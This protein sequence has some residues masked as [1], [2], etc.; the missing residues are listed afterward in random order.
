MATVVA[1]SGAARPSQRSPSG[2][3]AVAFAVGL[4]ALLL[5]A[6]MVATAALSAAGRLPFA[7]D[8][9][10]T[11]AEA[12]ALQ[13]GGEIERLLRRGADPEQAARVRA[14]IIRDVDMTMTPLEAAVIEDHPDVVDLLVREG[15]TIDA[16]NFAAL[17]C[18][19]QPHQDEV[20]LRFLQRWAAP[21]VP[22]DCSRVRTV[23]D[24]PQN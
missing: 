16:R 19:A 1:P 5:I 6:G 10:L 11:L 12:A 3:A 23:L 9:R 4:P 20:M 14:G 17:W 24:E 22:R 15:A 13:D 7:R 8:P 21:S 18:L 2:N